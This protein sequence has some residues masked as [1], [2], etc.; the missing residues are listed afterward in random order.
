MRFAAVNVALKRGVK[1]YEI[2][3]FIESRF[4]CWN[5][6]RLSKTPVYLSGMEI[7]FAHV[8]GSAGVPGPET[9]V[10]FCGS[11]PGHTSGEP[12]L[13]CVE[14]TKFGEIASGPCF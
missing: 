4:G 5:A 12:Y 2:A 14:N 7:E 13:P 9:G 3:R 10:Q 1:S 6:P 8:V 11:M